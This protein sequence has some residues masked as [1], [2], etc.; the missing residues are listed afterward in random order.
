MLLWPLRQY[1]SNLANEPVANGATAILGLLV[2]AGFG[3][4]ISTGS[5]K[6]NAPPESKL[7]RGQAHSSSSEFKKTG[8][9]Q[10]TGKFRKICLICGKEF[11]DEF[12]GKCP[13]DESELSRISDYLAPGTVFSEYYEII[14]PLGAGNL[15]RV[16]Q[17]RHISSGRNLAIKMLHSHLCND[18]LSVQRFQREA[19]ALSRLNHPNLV[20]V[21]D[22]MISPDGIPF[23]IMDYLEGESL[24][25]ILAREKSLGWQETASI[26]VQICKG[27]SHAHSK[28]IIHRDLK[29]GNVMIVLEKNGNKQAKVVDF[30]LAKTNQTDSI[31]R[32][33][34][35]GEVFGSPLYMS[36]EQC[37]GKTVDRRS[38]VYAVG[39]IMFECL[40]GKAPYHG[41]NI[42]DTLSMHLNSPVPEIPASSN[43][44]PWMVETVRK[45]L[46]KDPAKRQQSIEDLGGQLQ[47]GIGSSRGR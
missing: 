43:V 34:Q 13:Q 15:S 18:S 44:P 17:A 19:K 47:D 11:P 31:G 4:W 32:I 28:G 39:C 3:F 8:S 16:F 37:E 2:F 22:F 26:F 29:P 12:A 21:E 14:G 1:L 5:K 36:P 23:I 46:A 6:K 40:T 41:K 35:T 10:K 33:T 9:M 7:S 42:I 20:S 24:Q 27:L 25:Q 30:G 45:A 38:D